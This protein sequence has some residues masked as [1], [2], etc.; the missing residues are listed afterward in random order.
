[1][2]DSD[3]L[4]VA[5]VS[6]IG[7]TVV[8]LESDLF[9]PVTTPLTSDVRWLLVETEEFDGIGATGVVVDCVDVELDDE[10]CARAA[11]LISVTAIV[12]ASRVLIISY[13]PGISARAG[14]PA[15]GVTN[16]ILAMRRRQARKLLNRACCRA[17]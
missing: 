3:D 9:V 13:S 10:L 16:V 12:A 14:S 4:W 7:D 8:P 6:P 1:M 15:F 2:V 5:V 11:P 17:C